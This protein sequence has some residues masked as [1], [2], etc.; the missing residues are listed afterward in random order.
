MQHI[1]SQTAASSSANVWCQKRLDQLRKETE[2]AIHSNKNID[3]T[4]IALDQFINHSCV[5]TGR[6]STKLTPQNVILN[7]DACELIV[8]LQK[9]KRDNIQ[10]DLNRQI[11]TVSMAENQLLR[12]KSDLQQ[13]PMDENTLKL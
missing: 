6:F 3:T 8:K 4:L 9:K 12:A 13:M 11:V 5:Y 7:I 1:S 2:S 10:N